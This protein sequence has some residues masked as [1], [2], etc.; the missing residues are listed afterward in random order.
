[1]ILI[2]E[3]LGKDG[4]KN[5][6]KDYGNYLKLTVDI[7]RGEIV[8]GCELHPDGKRLLLQRDSKQADIWGGGINLKNGEID[9]TAVLNLRPTEAN[10]SLEILDLSR[11]NNFM[12]IVKKI[13]AVLWS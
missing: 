5:L 6:L 8:A 7:K 1:M 9:A 4:I 10:D 3:P 2:T 11:R 12:L 13:F